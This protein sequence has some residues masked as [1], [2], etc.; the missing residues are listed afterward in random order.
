MNNRDL[1]LL[2][3][4]ADTLCNRKP[5]QLIP[6]IRLFEEKHYL[7]ALKEYGRIVA[8]FELFYDLINEIII[9]VNY[10]DHRSWPKHRS[11]Q[12]LLVNHNLKT[13]YSAFE[14]A[15][16]GFYE[17]SL[18]LLRTNYEALVRVIWISCYPDRAGAGVHEHKDGGREFNLTEFIKDDL[19]LNWRSYK[20]L[21]VFTHGN[22]PAVMY[23][24]IDIFKKIKKEPISIELKFDKKYLEVALNYLIFLSYSYLKTTIDL[25]VTS[26]ND[27]LKEKTI[28]DGEKLLDIW[29]QSLLS[30]PGGY[31]P[32]LIKDLDDILKMCLSAD[33]GQNWRNTWNQIRALSV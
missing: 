5:R 26:K 15:I 20:F 17:D 11:L 24:W 12:L 18:N 10:I 28:T 9:G 27:L 25:F 7:V 23:D 14:R 2:R 21:S 6:E 8:Q 31:W 19:K 32:I 22:Q 29:K 30:H 3:Q 1:A 16:K 33:A 4:R 13:I